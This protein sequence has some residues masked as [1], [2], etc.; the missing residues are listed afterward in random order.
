MLATFKHEKKMII[1]HEIKHFNKLS[2]SEFHD[3]IKLRIETFILEQECVY[4]EVDGLD[5]V[6]FHLLL[7]KKDVL[8]GTSRIIPKGELYSEFSIGRIVIIAKERRQGY[9]S[10]L[11]EK[12]IEFIKSLDSKAV[13]RIDALK[14]IEKLYLSFGFTSEN[15]FNSFNY[16]YVEMKLDLKNLKTIG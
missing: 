8:I 3:L 1:S 10:Y 7:F 13:I 15:Y 5:T 11:V 4:P 9:G 12:S 16:E 14:Y 6:S 2:T